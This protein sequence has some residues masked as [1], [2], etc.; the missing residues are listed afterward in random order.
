MVLVSECEFKWFKRQNEVP[1]RSI[2]IRFNL[3]QNKFLDNVHPDMS[4]ILIS[5]TP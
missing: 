3:L 5:D 2:K 4:T 1:Y